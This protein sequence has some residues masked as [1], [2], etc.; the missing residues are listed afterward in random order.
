MKKQLLFLFAFRFVLVQGQIPASPVYTRLTAYSQRFA[1]AFS[2]TA[3]Q[4]SLAEAKHFSAGLYSE[5]RFLL[6][7]LSS[8]TAAL[9]LPT[10][11]GSFG[12][13]GCYSGEASFS[14]SSLGLAYGRNLG[15]KLALGLQFS[16]FGLQAAGYGSASTILVEGGLLFQLSP[17][18][19]V[20]AEAYNPLGNGLGKEGIEKLPTLYSVGTGVDLSPQVYIGVEAQK[21]KGW[22]VS[23]IGNIDYRP[24]ERLVLRLGLQPEAAAYFFGF[25]VQWKRFRV[26]VSVS[27]HPYLGTSP[28]LLLLYSSAE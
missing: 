23:M 11:S 2:F 5:K 12:L 6:K 17:Q 25:G 14:R 10:P 27:L 21:E 15:G 28:G 18:W 26:D 9:V 7:A 13:K 22:P 4:A 16:Y 3:N 1:D 8:Y 24:A 20:G 19:K